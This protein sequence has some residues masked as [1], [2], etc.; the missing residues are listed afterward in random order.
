MNLLDCLIFRSALFAA[1]QGADNDEDLVIFEKVSIS[2]REPK[3][4]LSLP[5]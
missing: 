3:N 4:L 1:Q 2:Y 5:I